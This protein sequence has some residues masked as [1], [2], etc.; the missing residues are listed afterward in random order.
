MQ[1]PLIL[2]LALTS[3][4]LCALAE[5]APERW[6]LQ[7]KP[8]KCTELQSTLIERGFLIKAAGKNFLAVARNPASARW[9]KEAKLGTVA[10]FGDLSQFGECVQLCCCD[11]AVSRGPGSPAGCGWCDLPRLHNPAQTASMQLVNTK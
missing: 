11:V 7:C 1:R 10:I 3:V 2:L 5:P 4:T 9:A 8:S 6:V